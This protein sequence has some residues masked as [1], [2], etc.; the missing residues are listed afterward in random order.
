MDQNI[1]SSNGDKPLLAG[2]DHIVMAAGT[3]DDENFAVFV[4]VGNDADVFVIGMKGE[5][6]ELRRARYCMICWS[7]GRIRFAD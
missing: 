2:N 1:R 4:P 6:P 7:S 5:I 3:M